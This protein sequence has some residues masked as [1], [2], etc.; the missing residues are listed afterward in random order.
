MTLTGATPPGSRRAGRSKRR[1][2]AYAVGAF[3][4]LGS[5]SA[6]VQP[7]TAT[8]PEPI[9]AAA[10]A[11][12]VATSTPT[13]TPTPTRA[14]PTPESTPEITP[15]PTPVFG[16]EPT[17]SVQVAT[18]T[19]V[20]D[21]D[22]IEVRLAG[23]LVRVRYIGMDTPETTG[24]W[25]AAP[26]RTANAAVVSGAN[27]RLEKD[28]SETDRYGRLLRYVWIEREGALLLVNR[29]L[30]VLGL[31][32][33]ATFPPDVKYT[34]EIFL[35]AEREA[36]DGGLGLWG[37]KPT[38]KPMA[39]PT[40]KRTSRPQP[41]NCHPSYAG[42]CLKMGIGDYDCAGGSGNG[43]NYTGIVR[44]VGYDEFDLD[45]DGDGYGCE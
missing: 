38:P 36:R 41:S 21:G 18:V 24:E 44:V 8:E 22:T 37:P 32:Q 28:V 2:A 17:G 19:R 5:V 23:R 27:V 3:V 14:A 31:A 12:P 13:A 29:E 15:D 20:I 43:P 39:T 40:P 26:A 25:M 6:V 4:V 42:A 35:P 34:D 1:L 45:R 9:S 10:A 11:G 30:L 7:R 33:V 16:Q